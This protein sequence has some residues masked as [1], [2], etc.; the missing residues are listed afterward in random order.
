MS[1]ARWEHFP[2]GADIGIRGVGPTIS[3][4]F[5]QVALALTAVL[6]DPSRV[7]S[8]D[9]VELVCEA[10]TDDELLYD[11]VD[12]LIYEMSTRGMLF[13]AFDVRVDGHRLVARALGEAVDRTRHEPAIEVKGPTYTEL[14][15]ARVDDGWVAQCVVD[16]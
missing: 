14:R 12:A 2:H 4:A 10:S 6:T 16:V 3:S 15:V 5:E 7:E 8:K 9:A 13:G 1:D 11:W